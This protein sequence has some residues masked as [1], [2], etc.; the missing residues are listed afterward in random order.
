MAFSRM[1]PSIEDAAVDPLEEANPLGPDRDR[2]DV[3]CGALGNRTPSPGISP[4]RYGPIA[5]CGTPRAAGERHE[6]SRREDRIATA[7]RMR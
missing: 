7:D 1:P 6:S 5:A 3:G 4:R 2:V